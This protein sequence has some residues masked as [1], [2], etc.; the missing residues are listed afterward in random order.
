MKTVITGF[1]IGFA[2]TVFA[3]LNNSFAGAPNCTGTTTITASG[4]DVYPSLSD[5]KISVSK[6]I[7]EFTAVHLPA[8]ASQ[9]D[10]FTIE[11]NSSYEMDEC[12][13]YWDEYDER[14]VQLCW[15]AGV[16][17]TAVDYP[18]ETVEQSA[19]VSLSGYYVPSA[20]ARQRVKY[21]LLG[22]DWVGTYSTF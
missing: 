20:P 1:I 5:C 16:D 17:I 11:D 18:N 22:T 7:F 21:I 9:G 19:S 6:S 10:E 12:I 3:L 8:G 14:M 15:P 13:E 4:V 2:L